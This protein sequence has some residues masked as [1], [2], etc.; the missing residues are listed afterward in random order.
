M[1]FIEV[2]SGLISVSNVKEQK[3]NYKKSVGKKMIYY[4]QTSTV[5]SVFIPVILLDL[6]NHEMSTAI[7]CCSRLPKGVFGNWGEIK[8]PGQ[9][10]P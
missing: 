10:T 3:K 1:V 8:R 9:T 2:L 7:Y 4:L 5:D 6:L